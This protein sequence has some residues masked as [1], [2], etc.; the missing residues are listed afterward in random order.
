MLNTLTCEF[1]FVWKNT[2]DAI[3]ITSNPY[4]N[5]INITAMKPG[6]SSI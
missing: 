1:K 3:M 5:G 6:D 2:G 4:K